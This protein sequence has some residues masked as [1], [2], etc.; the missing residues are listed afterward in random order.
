MCLD[1]C[2]YPLYVSGSQDVR[3]EI[4]RDTGKK[5]IIKYSVTLPSYV[6]CSQCVIQ[7]NYF[8]G[9]YFTTLLHL[10]FPCR[11]WKFAYSVSCTA[12]N[13]WG[14]CENGTEAV[15]CG[16]PETFRNCADVRIVTS[17]GGIPPRFLSQ[18]DIFQLYSTPPKF[19]IAPLARPLRWDRAALLRIRVSI[20]ERQERNR[21]CVFFLIYFGDIFQLCVLLFQSSSLRGGCSL[22]IQTK[23]DRLVSSELHSRPFKLS[24]GH[25]SLSVS[26][27]LRSNGAQYF[28]QGTESNFFSF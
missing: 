7:W 5:G 15:G 25:L 20:S 17:T 21:S 6:T 3:F 19:S 1:A 27:K 24:T 11:F 23:H 9:K 8:T 14:T 2:S 10:P 18:N 4:P 28:I 26:F 12:G 22:P 13:M 16:A